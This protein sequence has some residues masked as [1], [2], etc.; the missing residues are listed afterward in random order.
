M[1]F[2][3]YGV[4]EVHILLCETYP[5]TK[6]FDEESFDLINY[7]QVIFY[8]RDGPAPHPPQ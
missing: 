7:L 3:R 4:K 2:M 8:S 5:V 6:G 1:D